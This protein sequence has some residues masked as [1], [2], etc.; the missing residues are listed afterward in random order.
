M[1]MRS[2][3]SISILL[4]DDHPVFRKGLKD[5][6]AEKAGLRVVGETGNGSEVE[7]LVGELR[8]DVLLL[9]LNLPGKD[10]LK[11]AQDLV[12]RESATRIV[13]LTMHREEAMFNR[14]MDIGV[15]GYVLKESAVQDI[16]DSI[17]AVTRDEYFISP[18]IS[19]YLVRRTA[20]RRSLYESNPGLE[21]LTPA[22]RRVLN[23]V[24]ANKSSKEIA[25]TLFVSVRTV[26]NHRQ[27]I[28][29]KLGLRG[30]NSLLKFAIENRSR[31]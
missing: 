8:P 6:I 26:E 19:G 10:G 30:S 21:E 1:M 5:I 16:I 20:E 22:E 28:S 4:A 9:D 17:G 18:A 12:S 11:I 25:E 15:H 3:E 7:G 23:L 29:S 14:A 27:N 2:V 13:I 31:L 24:A